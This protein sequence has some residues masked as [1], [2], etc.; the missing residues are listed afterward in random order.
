MPRHEPAARLIDIR[1]AA[2]RILE[3]VADITIDDYRGDWRIRS[4]I[5]RQLITAGEAGAA[6]RREFPDVAARITDIDRIIAFRNILV[7]G[8]SSVDDAIVW[9][10]ISTKL[11]T[12]RNETVQLVSE[13]TR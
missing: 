12:L 2:D 11:Q 9:G 3:V 5:E 8:Y 7:H 10:I 4:A 6:I 13:L 1:D